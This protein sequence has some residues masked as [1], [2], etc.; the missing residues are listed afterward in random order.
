MGQKFCE[1]NLN[2]KNYLTN[3]VLMIASGNLG[4]IK[5]FRLLLRNFPIQV[6]SP[7]NGFEVNETGQT[8]AENARLKALEVAKQTGEWAL[9]DD[10]GLC[11]NSLL[12]AP[13]IYSS[14]YAKNDKQRI[15]RLLKELDKFEDRRAHFKAA[16][17][18]ASENRVLL[19][20]EGICEGVITHLPRGKNGFG[21]DPIFEVLG[22]GRTFAEMG[23]EEK[24]ALGHRG[25]AFNL[26]VPGLIELLKGPD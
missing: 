24:K 19:E 4:K 26:L 18:I 14:R 23:I 7:S 9:A 6:Q 8:F 10:S 12:G 11:V 21:Y 16:L 1:I 13:G 3:R 22:T 20:V 17:C 2:N 25:I 5:E 15:N